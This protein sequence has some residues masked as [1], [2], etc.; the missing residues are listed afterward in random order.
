V[1]REG[2]GRKEEQ[3]PEIWAENS[4]LAREISL[5][6]LFS[7]SGVPNSRVKR[8]GFLT[9]FHLYLLFYVK[10]TSSLFYETGQ[11]LQQGAQEKEDWRWG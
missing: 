4:S 5:F 3:I 8:E 2:R 11:A 7:A 1:K 6:P 9:F 10:E